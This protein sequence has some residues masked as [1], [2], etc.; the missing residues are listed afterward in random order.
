LSFAT[1]QFA[2]IAIAAN[3]ARFFTQNQELKTITTVAAKRPFA[4]VAA[5]ATAANPV[6]HRNLHSSLSMNLELKTN[7]Q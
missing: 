5:A 6:M 1:K 7:N 4:K 3:L 2:A